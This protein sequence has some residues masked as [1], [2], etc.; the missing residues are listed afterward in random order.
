MTSQL[1]IGPE[2]CSCGCTMTRMERA[3]G[4]QCYW[5]RSTITSPTPSPILC[6]IVFLKTST[7]CNRVEFRLSVTPSLIAVTR[8]NENVVCYQLGPA[9]EPPIA[10]RIASHLGTTPAVIHNILNLLVGEAS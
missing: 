9:S 2:K 8:D 7:G 3:T 1:N 5:C 4:T 10:D 6:V